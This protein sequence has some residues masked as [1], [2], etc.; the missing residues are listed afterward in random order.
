M[1]SKRIGRPRKP[2]AQLKLCGTY[3]KDRRYKS[4]PTS[5]TAIPEIPKFLK[6]EARKE[7]NRL[8]PLLAKSRCLTEWDRSL[9]A[10]YCFEWGIYAGLCSRKISKPELLRAR[11]KAFQNFTKAAIEFGLSPSSRTRIA[12]RPKEEKT[13]PFQT[14]LNRGKNAS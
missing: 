1:G 5:K 6:N 12:V 7:W 9:L 4:E 11:N 3:R 10:A 8:A 13:D 2:T 14:L